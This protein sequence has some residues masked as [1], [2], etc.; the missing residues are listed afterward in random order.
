MSTTHHD[1]AARRIPTHHLV[2]ELKRREMPITSYAVLRAPAEAP[3]IEV[4]LGF[5]TAAWR[6]LVAELR[7]TEVK[8][9]SALVRAHPSPVRT[10]DL[11][12][13]F[14]SD[15]EP[16]EAAQSVRTYICYLR[17]HL[18]GLIGNSQHTGYWLNLGKVA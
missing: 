18:P 4:D 11:A 12:G 17:R 14:W 5:Q 1:R 9:L 3:E 13:M 15:F 6:G 7:P 2:R 8:V 10:R 16:P